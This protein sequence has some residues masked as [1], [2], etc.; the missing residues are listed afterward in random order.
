MKVVKETPFDFDK[1]SMDLFY[2]KNIKK[3]L[4]LESWN[5]DI[6]CD[7]VDKNI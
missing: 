7:Y 4:E 3:A 2:L 1:Y 5:G 6:F